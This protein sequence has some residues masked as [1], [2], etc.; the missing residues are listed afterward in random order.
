MNYK[1]MCNIIRY[2]LPEYQSGLCITNKNTPYK[3]P[4]IF[5]LNFFYTNPLRLTDKIHI[6]KYTIQVVFFY[7]QLAQS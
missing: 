7:A 6:I 1:F 5:L 3:Q 4:Q 2:L